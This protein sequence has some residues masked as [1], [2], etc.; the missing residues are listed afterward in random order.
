MAARR[1][2]LPDQ[3]ILPN[4]EIAPN[5]KVLFAVE[6]VDPIAQ[7]A[8]YRGVNVT[9]AGLRS[10]PILNKSGRFVWLEEGDR[11]PG[12][13]SVIPEDAPFAGQ[14]APAPPRPVDLAKARQEERLV[15]ITL[16]PAPAYPLED[17]ITA[18]R[19]RLCEGDEKDSP[20]IAGARVQLAWHDL[21]S[22]NWL[23]PKPLPQDFG[24]DGGDPP[25]P[26]EPETDRNGEFV[27]FLR[28]NP[29]MP[30]QPDLE[31]GMLAVRLQITRDRKNPVTRATPDDF[32]FLADSNAAGSHPA[33]NGEPQST[34]GRIPEGRLLARDLTITWTMLNPI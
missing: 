20:P 31:N 6:L 23:P 3:K 4:N 11:W 1:Q 27:V 5:R 2:G 33:S 34:K 28:L 25:S 12:A 19:G 30:A 13:I 24:A 17:G 7:S 8:V 22:D 15:R 16:R 9:A 18:I 26:P 29:P 21:T 14:I 32:P 10:S